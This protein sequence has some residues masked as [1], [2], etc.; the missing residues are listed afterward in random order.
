MGSTNRY[1]PSLQSQLQYL[2]EWFQEFSE[3]QRNDFL[4][5]LIQRFGHKEYVNGFLPEME[6]E[7]NFNDRPPSLFQC[8][9]KLFL[10]WTES[11]GQDEKQQLLNIIKS[12][13]PNFSD[14]YETKVNSELNAC[15]EDEPIVLSSE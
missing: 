14:K 12:I 2:V 7:N 9:I 4:P 1:I 13:D 15:S 10:E 11:W 6:N 5:V 8:R 3:M